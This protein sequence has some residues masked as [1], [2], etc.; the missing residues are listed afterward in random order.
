MRPDIT[1]EMMQQMVL[2]GFDNPFHL[3]GGTD[4]G[5][6]LKMFCGA[7]G[8]LYTLTHWVRDQQALSIEQAVHCMTARNA[9]FFSLHDRGILDVGRRGDLSV[10]ALD[11][12]ET[13]GLERVHDLPDGGWRFTRPSA[14]FRATVVGGVPT[15]LDGKPTGERPT[16]IGNARAS[17][18][19]Q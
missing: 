7:G 19:V 10:F 6:H 14:G 4:A 15:V 8:N 13:R 17:S 16:T 3:M 12:I 1:P 18:G 9:S 11:E 2:E 5:A